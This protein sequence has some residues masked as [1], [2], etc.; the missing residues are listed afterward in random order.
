MN[1]SRSAFPPC[2]AAPDIGLEPCNHWRELPSVKRSNG[3]ILRCPAQRHQ[4][5]VEVAETALELVDNPVVRKRLA[6]G[7]STRI[8]R[9]M[10][11]IST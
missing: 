1:G 4:G 5:F 11:F 10:V 8:S 9:T 6:D 7:E 3:W 2:R